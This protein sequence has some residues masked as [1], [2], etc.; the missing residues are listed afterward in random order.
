MALS[1]PDTGGL[2]SKLGCS[3]CALPM[4]IVLVAIGLPA[5]VFYFAD[6][7][8]KQTLLA[9]DERHFDPI[10]D[11][12][13]ATTL[14]GD[15]LEFVGMKAEFV[16]PDG[17]LD[18]AADYR[19]SVTYEWRGKPQIE[20]SRPVGAGG[21]STSASRVTVRVTAFGFEHTGTDHEGAQLYDLNLGM[22]RREHRA[23]MRTNQ[24]AAPPP[25]CGLKGIWSAAKQAGAPARAVAVIDYDASGYTFRIQGTGFEM[26]FGQDCKPLR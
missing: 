8:E 13:Y 2:A 23:P 9:G 26:R 12:G 5:I 1:E 10:G 17:T 6:I 14:A 4:G 20:T 7:H 24:A 22:R 11:I 25:A 19:P 16:Q 15:G 21:G 18:L 3:G